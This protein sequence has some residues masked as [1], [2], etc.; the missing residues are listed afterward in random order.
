MG[1][2]DLA[3]PR[4]RD[5]SYLPS[6]FEPRRRAERALLAV[7]QEAYVLG[8][9]TRRVEDLVEALG[10]ASLSWT[11]WRSRAPPRCSTGGSR[12]PARTP[13]GRGPGAPV[14]PAGGVR[15]GRAGSCRLEC[16]GSPRSIVPTR[17]SQRRSA[18]A[19][20]ARV[21]VAVGHA[22]ELGHP[23]PRPRPAPAPAAPSPQ[24]VN[25][26]VGDRPCAPSRAPPIGHCRVSL[27][28]VGCY[29]NNVR[30]TQWQFR[31]RPDCCYTNSGG[32]APEAA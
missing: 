12:R 4:V 8:V 7:V 13:P 18:I 31:S 16:A 11:G 29:S 1:T 2:I 15:T 32:L 21:A 5:G 25:V 20:G 17:L 3:I 22:G 19:V 27:S 14:R 9:S 30:M 26:T 23:R 6:L 10:I 24:E 28:V